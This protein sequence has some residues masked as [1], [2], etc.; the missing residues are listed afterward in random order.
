MWWA[1][2]SG[3]QC[4][5]GMGWPDHVLCGAAC[6]G[7]G[8][9]LF[10]MNSSPATSCCNAVLPTAQLTSVLALRH[11]SSLKLLRA[12]PSHLGRTSVGMH[13]FDFEQLTIETQT[14]TEKSER[15]KMEALRLKCK[16][17]MAVQ[18]TS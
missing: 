6:N 10:R 8:V 12:V 3:P 5:F 7:Y 11:S 18:V 16:R 17:A 4:S 2:G 9:T 13:A 1:Q 14:M 15:R